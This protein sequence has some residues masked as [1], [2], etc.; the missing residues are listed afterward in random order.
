[1]IEGRQNVTKYSFAHRNHSCPVPVNS[2]AR[3]PLGTYTGILYVA[4]TVPRAG[5]SES[6]Q[7]R[8][9]NDQWQILYI[10]HRATR[11]NVMNSRMKL[12]LSV[13]RCC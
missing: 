7:D 8:S 9:L 12:P 11:G 5:V 13:L 2:A 6:W 4:T 3:V 1:M 10:C